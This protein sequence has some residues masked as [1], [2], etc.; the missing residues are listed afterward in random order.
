VSEN[1]LGEEGL[2]TKVNHGYVNTKR[3]VWLFTNGKDSYQT[4]GYYNSVFDIFKHQRVQKA[5]D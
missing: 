2:L 5:Q 1:K 4:H 3:G